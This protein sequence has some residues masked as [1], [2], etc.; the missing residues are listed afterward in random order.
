LRSF[1]GPD[2]GMEDKYVSLPFPQL[3]MPTSRTP[4]V[5]EV[6]N[7]QPV[8][9]D[10]G[11]SISVRLYSDCR[12]HCLETATLQKGLVLLA[13]GEELIEEG[14][15][16]GVPVVIY[17]DEP[18]FS[19]TSQCEAINQA[20]RS[21]LVKSFLMDTVSR[22]KVGEVCY[23]NN[24][25]YSLFHKVFHRVYAKNSCFTPLF[26]KGI[27]IT[28]RLGINTD[29][30]KVKPRGVIKVKY[31]CLSNSIEVEAS[32]DQLEKEQCRE[33]VLLNEQGASFFRKYSD[34]D[35]LSLF[36]G[37]IGAWVPINADR[38]SLSDAGETMTFS[39]TKRREANFFRGR[40]KIRNR[41]SWVGLG[42][43]F[44]PTSSTF[45]YVIELKSP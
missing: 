18:Y 27:E 3:E 16:F 9:V 30:V 8:T 36:E 32:F 24:E 11:G 6:L 37:Q 29:F 34:S 21:T 43:S 15:G 41:Y 28:K 1:S 25:L 45:R 7:S 2:S 10:V 44:R 33:I 40:E 14:V 26:N 35:K 5:G 20:H 31:T 17:K 38:A 4:I 42:Y 23:V 39:L 12:P 22:K 13:D 19:G